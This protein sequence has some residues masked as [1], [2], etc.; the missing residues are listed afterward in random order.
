MQLNPFRKK[1][2]A[3]FTLIEMMAIVIIVGILY[4]TAAPNLRTFLANQQVKEVARGLLSG[5]Q[6]ARSFAIARNGNISIIYNGKSW[7][8]FDRGVSM[9]FACDTSTTVLE[10]GEL[11]KFIA[12]PSPTVDVEF[13]PSDSIELTFNGVG[14]IIGNGDGSEPIAELN[15]STDDGFDRVY[16]VDFSNGTMRMC[17]A[18]LIRPGDP[19]AC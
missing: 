1:R 8:I 18:T 2:S 14:R 13:V 5:A 12:A 4:A 16:R 17:E 3:G 7:C 15:V 19:R 11:R 6:E 10:V 9:S